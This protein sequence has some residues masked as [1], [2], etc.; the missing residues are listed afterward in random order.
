M[1]LEKYHED[2]NVLG[3]NTQK[4]HAYFI[5]FADKESIEAVSDLLSEDPLED[6]RAYSSRVY[7]LNGEWEFKYYQDYRDIPPSFG[8]SR[9]LA[10]ENAESLEVPSNWE[11]EGYGQAQ[12]INVR[13]PIPQDPPFLPDENPCGAY[14]KVFYL[15]EAELEDLSRVFINFEGVDACLYLWFNGEFIGYSEASHMSHEFELTDYLGIGENLLQVLVFQYSTG[16]YLEDQDKFR[17]SGIFRDVYLI[18]RPETFIADYEISQ[19]FNEDLSEVSLKVDLTWSAEPDEEVL[20]SLLI[21]VIDPLENTVIA[22]LKP[23]EFKNLGKLRLWNAEE[24]NIYYL[25]MSYKGEA[26]RQ[27]LAFRKISI[28]DDT[29]YINNQKV[30]LKGVNR[31][32]SDPKTGYYISPEQLIKDLSIMK[33]HNINAIRTS[34]YPN[35]PFAYEYYTRLGFYVIDEADIEMHGSQYLDGEFM[36]QYPKESRR[37]D[38][39]TPNSSFSYYAN[40][41]IFDAAILDRVERMYYRDRNQG[42]III[43]SLGNEAGYG[44]GFKKAAEF[45]G[46]K[47]PS[48]K[49]SYEGVISQRP[50]FDSDLKEIDFYSRMYTPI[51]Y[52][53]YYASHEEKKPFLLIEYMHAMGNGP[54]QIEDY[55]QRF[56]EHDCFVGGFA[57]EWADHAIYKGKKEQQEIFYYGGDSGETEHDGNF[58]VD[59][60][61]KPN[62]EISPSL[63]EYANVLRPIRAEIDKDKAL[64]GKLKLKNMLDFK[65]VGELCLVECNYISNGEIVL[66]SNI[67]DFSIPA[68][69]SLEIDLELSEEDKAALKSLENTNLSLVLYYLNISQN[70]LIE[71][72]KLLGTDEI[73]IN[74]LEGNYLDRVSELYPEFKY[75]ST[76]DSLEVREN[77]DELSL[78]SKDFVYIFDKRKGNFKYLSYKNRII[79]DRLIEYN[80]WRA[81]TD[82]DMY[83]KNEWKQKGFDCLRSKLKDLNIEYL[84]EGVIIKTHISMGAN[85]LL[86]V[87]QIYTTWTINLDGVIDLAINV[88]RERDLPWNNGFKDFALSQEAKQKPEV[89]LPRFGLRIFMPKGFEYLTFYGYGPH[90]SYEDMHTASY[91]SE[92]KQTV[93]G[94]YEDF[95]MP[96]EHGSHYK[97]KSALL[98]D[99]FLSALF[100]S[101]EDDFSFNASHYSQEELARKGHNFELEESNYT[102]LCLDYKMSGLGSNSC[103][104]RPFLKDCLTATKFSFNLSLVPGRIE[105]E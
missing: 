99:D 39:E 88:D 43:W 21:E 103:G 27:D 90:A 40:L 67:V 54:G 47:D 31:H 79:T 57:W 62:R 50:Y 77:E 38:D 78:V 14:E 7:S 4:P 48:R 44:P 23:G 75:G 86:P 56:Y 91:F 98:Y 6:I 81:P 72:F 64:E 105:S 26:I 60:L 83:V 95:I 36:G 1:H 92:F 71:P 46:A 52:L 20:D 100:V 65:D 28:V 85:G 96:Q 49:L 15:D 34:H 42:S 11:L 63:I 58:C 2:P 16:S 70:P 53:D 51:S 17:L 104:P 94:Q 61:I 41:G 84:E 30:K 76:A 66:R 87:A 55:W 97:S 9:C 102:I 68:H 101:S 59:G 24:A 13:Y 22:N 12:Y 45:L 8:Q 10:Y 82:N 89:Y 93:S 74:K 32:D 3:V 80:F 73:I 69:E 19:D 35:A 5:P 25:H 33:S 18:D 29:F 37:E